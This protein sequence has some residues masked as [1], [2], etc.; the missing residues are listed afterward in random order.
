[1]YNT[2]IFPIS[3]TLGGFCSDTTACSGTNVKAC[4]TADAVC[5]CEDTFTAYNGKC[6]AAS[7]FIIAFFF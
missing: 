3:G 6:V 2:F 5:V 1:M 4:V 7:M